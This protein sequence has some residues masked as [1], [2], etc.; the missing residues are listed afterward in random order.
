MKKVSKKAKR[1]MIIIVSLM[2]VVSAV[3]VKSVYSDWQTIFKNKR[4]AGELTE[5]YEGLLESEKSLEAEVIKFQ[6]PDYVAR[7]AREKHLYT[8]PDELIIKI[9]KKD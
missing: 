3:L 4:S 5:K 8:L 7:Y 6:D 2:I 1:R 9:P